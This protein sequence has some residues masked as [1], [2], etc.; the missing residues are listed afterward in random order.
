MNLVETNSGL[1]YLEVAYFVETN[2][3][4]IYLCIYENSDEDNFWKTYRVGKIYE[5]DNSELDTIIE[6][7]HK[8]II[9]KSEIANTYLFKLFLENLKN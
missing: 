7:K 4:G 8:M 9:E 5:L 2:E 3:N 6:S 1:G